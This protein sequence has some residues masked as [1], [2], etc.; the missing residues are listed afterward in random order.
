[1]QNNE[2]EI[3]KKLDNNI[4]IELIRFNAKQLSVI[5]IDPKTKTIFGMN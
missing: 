4:D 5:F 1:M 2:N 3:I